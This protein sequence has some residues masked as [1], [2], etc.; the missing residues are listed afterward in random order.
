MWGQPRGH[1]EST[2]GW[3]AAVPFTISRGCFTKIG[4]GLRPAPAERRGG[5]TRPTARHRRLEWSWRCKPAA[6]RR[7]PSHPRSSDQLLSTSTGSPAPRD[8]AGRGV[9]SGPPW[10]SRYGRHGWPPGSLRPLAIPVAD[11]KRRRP[12]PGELF[13]ASAPDPFSRTRA[14]ALPPVRARGQRTTGHEESPDRRR[15][16]SARSLRGSDLRC[17]RGTQPTEPPLR[18]REWSP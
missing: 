13:P 11:R 10:G 7:A 15:S 18:A 3:L 4:R 2:G 1:P 16:R 17:W 6:P 12:D 5:G 14:E 8:V 9:E